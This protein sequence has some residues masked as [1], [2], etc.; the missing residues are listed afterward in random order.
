MTRMLTRSISSLLDKKKDFY[1]SNIR[2]LEALNPLA[3]MTR[4]Y[5]VAYKDVQVV[6]SIT[7]LTKDDEIMIHFH[8]GK[9]QAKIINTLEQKEANSSWK[10]NKPLQ[11]VWQS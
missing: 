6:N 5:S 2:T 8:D 11:K 4:G 7:K 9:A 3:I 1:I 10:I